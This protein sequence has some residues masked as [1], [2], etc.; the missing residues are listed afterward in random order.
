[1]K[2]NRTQMDN[3]RIQYVPAVPKIIRNDNFGSFPE[4]Q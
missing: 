4:V 1:M 2:P 3:V